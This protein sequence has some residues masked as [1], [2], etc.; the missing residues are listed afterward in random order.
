MDP[1]K[2]DSLRMLDDMIARRTSDRQ[3]DG[4][5]PAPHLKLESSGDSLDELLSEVPC[6]QVSLGVSAG[7]YSSGLNVALQRWP[8]VDTESIVAPK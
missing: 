8:Q 4:A 5:V 6:E 3:S 2:D 1:M 7:I